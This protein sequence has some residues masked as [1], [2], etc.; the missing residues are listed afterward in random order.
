[1]YRT[2]L[3]R[4][5]PDPCVRLTVRY[6]VRSCGPALPVGLVLGMALGLLSDDVCASVLCVL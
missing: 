2:A 5:V 1:M 3:S 6:E 4:G